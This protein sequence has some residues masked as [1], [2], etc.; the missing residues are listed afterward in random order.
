[1]LRQPSAGGESTTGR[2]RVRPAAAQRLRRTASLAMPGPSLRGPSGRPRALPPGAPM[3][4]KPSARR[5]FLLRQPSAGGESTTRSGVPLARSRCQAPLARHRLPALPHERCLTPL[6][7][8]TL[9]RRH[10]AVACRP[11]PPWLAPPAAKVARREAGPPSTARVGAMPESGPRTALWHQE[12]AGTAAAEPG[13]DTANPT[14]SRGGGSTGTAP[15]PRS[16]SGAAPAGSPAS[17]RVPA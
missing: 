16:P 3:N 10:R 14:T 2:V 7:R 9:C 8:V 13:T 1:L 12:V 5:A 17:S 15:P 11:S 4:E 6:G